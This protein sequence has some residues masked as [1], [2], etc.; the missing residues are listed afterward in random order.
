MY[1]RI[2]LV[3]TASYFFTDPCLSII[4]GYGAHC[5]V[6][7]DKPNCVCPDIT[8]CHNVFAPVCGSNG[9]TY[10]NECRLKDDQCLSQ[11]RIKI[12]SE[13]ACGKKTAYISTCMKIWWEVCRNSAEH[14]A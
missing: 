8:T 14:A 12:E 13:T 5:E 1:Y 9:V 11:K 2:D 6:I 7:K 4:C 10:P 3:N